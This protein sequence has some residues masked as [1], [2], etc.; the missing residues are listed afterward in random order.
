MNITRDRLHRSITSIL[1]AV[2]R[3]LR[4]DRGDVPGWVMITLMTAA[5][6]VGLWAV[7]SEQLIIIFNNAMQPFLSGV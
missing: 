1:S 4:A 2:S 3:R 5:I 6:V 7:A